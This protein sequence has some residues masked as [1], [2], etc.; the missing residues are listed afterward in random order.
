M[1]ILL[2]AGL[3]LLLTSC[4][5]VGSDSWCENLNEKPKGDWTASEAGD[6]TRY[7]VLGLN[8]DSED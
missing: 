4:A 8:P 1:T 6:Y 2:T 3:F 7:C 5:K